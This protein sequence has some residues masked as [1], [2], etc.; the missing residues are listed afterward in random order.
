[1]SIVT[2]TGDDGST[3]LI[4][5]IRVPKDDVRMHAIGSVDELNAALGSS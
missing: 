1:M 5:N 4:G 2:K 3:G